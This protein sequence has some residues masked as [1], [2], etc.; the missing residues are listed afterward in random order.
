MRLSNLLPL[1]LSAALCIGAACGSDSEQRTSSGITVDDSNAGEDKPTKDAGKPASKDSGVKRDAGGG[2]QQTTSLDPETCDKLNISARPQ[3]PR[4]LI[5]QDRS[6]SMV[7]YGDARNMG[8]NRWAPSVSAIK[9]VTSDLTETVAFGLM[10]FPSKA[11]GA[12][13]RPNPAASC[14]PGKLNVPVEIMSADAIAMAL[15]ANTPDVGATPTASTL[16]VARGALKEDAC[17]DC[18]APPPM[19][20]LLV[21]DGQPT[22]GANGGATPTGEEIDATVAAIEEL[23]KDNITTYVIG[24]DTASDAPAAA[25]MDLFAM[26][27]GTDKHLPVEDEASLLSELTRIA[28]QLVPCEFEL[29]SDIPDPTYVRVE[30][31]GVTYEYMKD[32]QVEGRKIV[33]T[34]DGG[35]CPK[36]RD[37]KVHELK[38][39]RECKPIQAL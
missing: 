25:A 23:R 5:V 37:A 2:K 4:I 3:A 27:G 29:S 10:L 20:V 14:G 7:G 28:G 16:E 6:G 34:P 8:K 31:D 18:P 38:I 15:D 30:I 21:T 36:L 1:S 24:Y 26:A 9:K 39:T 19:Y 17:A 12:F 13:G 33:L 22:C 32:W 35:A 11:A